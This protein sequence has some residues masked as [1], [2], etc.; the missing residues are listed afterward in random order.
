MT[1]DKW[2]KCEC[3][4]VTCCLVHITEEGAVKYNWSKVSK[5]GVRKIEQDDWNCLEF[6]VRG[7]E[8]TEDEAL[9]EVL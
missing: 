1:K 9:V 6:K 2:I 5:P 3:Y 8:I 4:G 7:K